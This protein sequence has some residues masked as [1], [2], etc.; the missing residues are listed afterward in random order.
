MIRGAA[1]RLCFVIS[2]GKCDIL[3]YYGAGAWGADIAYVVQPRPVGL[4][5]A[6]FR[7]AALIG[8]TEPV[9]IGLPDTIWSSPDALQSPPCDVHSLLLFPV[10]HPGFFD[11][12]L[13]HSPGCVIN[14]IVNEC[15]ANRQ[16][17]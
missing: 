16:C 12:V 3:E 6:V 1:D 11:L 17:S 15:G 10:L 4:S 5:D 2:R 9:V 8:Q 14:M 7:A 13:T